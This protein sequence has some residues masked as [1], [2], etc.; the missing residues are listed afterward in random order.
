MTSS[1]AQK[2]DAKDHL[3]LEVAAEMFHACLSGALY[4]PRM[5]ALLV[6]DLHLEK[7][8]H[9]AQKGLFLPPY[10]S[11]ETL[12]Q[13]EATIAKWQPRQVICLG[14]SF[15]DEDGVKRLEPEC[16]DLL[17][18]LIAK[19]DWH[20][21]VGNHDPQAPLHLGG[22]GHQAMMFDRTGL[23]HEPGELLPL[24]GESEHE[25]SLEISGHLHPVATVRPRGRSLRRRC[26]VINGDRIILP[27][28]GAYTGGL[29]VGQE[30]FAKIVGK[31]TRLALLGRESLSLVA[32][33][34]PTMR[35]AR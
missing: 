8:S 19:Q 18:S 28:F 5:E 9:Y 10:D 29:N 22:Q 12:R 34:A 31:K 17:Q 14:D 2:H 24:D 7:G 35:G 15:H 4:W 1:P 27:A 6:A 3:A 32:Y 16:Q 23:C 25:T 13:L 33:H 21:V 26:F 20:W 11:R 30:P